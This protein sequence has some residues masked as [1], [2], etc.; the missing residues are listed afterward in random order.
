MPRS[1][2]PADFLAEIIRDR[3]AASPAFPALVEAALRDRRLLRSLRAER[4]RAG[5]T[6]AAVA[7][8]MGTSQEAISRLERG[9]ADP[10]LSTLERYA[11]AIAANMPPDSKTA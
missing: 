11:A 6:Q 3:T 5:I 8:V 9:E 2:P 1:T 10:R 7:R 4:R